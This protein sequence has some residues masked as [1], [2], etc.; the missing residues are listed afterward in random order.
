MFYFIHPFGT[1]MITD[2]IARFKWTKKVNLNNL[3][4]IL[5][6]SKHY[7]YLIYNVIIHVIY[8]LMEAM[9]RPTLIVLQMYSTFAY[10][11]KTIVLVLIYG[12]PRVGTLGRLASLINLS[13]TNKM[14]RGILLVMLIT[15]DFC[16]L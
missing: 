3:M 10:I 7:F 15:L 4:S 9:Y 12:T 11:L 6:Y 14:F 16:S 2:T 8:L 13:I 1:T 5:F